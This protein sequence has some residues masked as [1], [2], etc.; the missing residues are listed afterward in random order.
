MK[1][2][3]IT[4]AD[5]AMPESIHEFVTEVS[6]GNYVICLNA[7]DDTIEQ[8]ASA[9][10]AFA[11]ILRDDFSKIEDI[12]TTEQNLETMLLQ[13]ADCWVSSSKGESYAS[14]RMKV[15]R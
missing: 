15:V 13:V 2:F 7:G 9:L 10:H 14:S 1:K 11:H 3:E 6:D 5:E 8:L 4:I 12:D